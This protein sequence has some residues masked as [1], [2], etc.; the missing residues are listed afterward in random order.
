MLYI[1]LKGLH[2]KMQSE[3]SGYYPIIV[4]MNFEGTRNGFLKS[5]INTL[6]LQNLH[7]YPGVYSDPST[8]D[9]TFNPLTQQS[10]VT[11]NNVLPVID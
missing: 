5:F 10:K 9:V 11:V 4:L 2:E 7:I 3:L 8:Q 1:N 6:F